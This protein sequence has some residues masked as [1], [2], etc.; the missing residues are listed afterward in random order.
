MADLQTVTTAR[1]R[2]TWY[3]LNTISLQRFLLLR[4]A[5][6][7]AA[8][9]KSAAEQHTTKAWQSGMA[10]HRRGHQW[11]P[12]CPNEHPPYA[13]P[14]GVL[15]RH[16]IPCNL[17]ATSSTTEVAEP[18]R[19]LAWPHVNAITRRA[20]LC[21]PW[22]HRNTKRQPRLTLTPSYNILYPRRPSPRC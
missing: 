14:T 10:D 3:V 19:C 6:V 2:A 22:L 9:Q 4:A 13:C 11:C 1:P 16:T 20:S 5:R 7:A 21:L 12:L 8:E 17:S 18:G 15:A